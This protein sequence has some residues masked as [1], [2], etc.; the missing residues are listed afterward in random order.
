MKG[1]TLIDGTGRPP[2]P[3]AV[4][5]IEGDQFTQVGGRATSYPANATVLDFSGKFILPGLVDSHTHY[6]PWCGE[7][8]LN[9]GVTT[10]F[11]L[12]PWTFYGNTQASRQQSQESGVRSPRIF[13]IADRFLLSPAMNRE[14]VREQARQWL[15][16]KPD[17]A[18]LPS[19]NEG[20]Q[21]AYQWA[22]EALHEA[23]LFV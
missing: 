4:I 16:K 15:A 20:N 14:Q 9:H 10:V 7:L 11:F 13:G 1:A 3:E 5:I 17:F 19:Y 22:A 12:N 23:G 2:I 21:Q 18:V 8:Y 6:R